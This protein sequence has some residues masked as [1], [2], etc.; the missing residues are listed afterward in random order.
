MLDQPS[1]RTAEMACTTSCTCDSEIVN[2]EL[3][4]VQQECGVPLWR[5]GMTT[6][7]DLTGAR[8]AGGRSGGRGTALSVA[9]I[10]FK[11]LVNLTDHF[12]ETGLIRSGDELHTDNLVVVALED[13]RITLFVTSDDNGSATQVALLLA[14]WVS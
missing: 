1:S 6:H 13:G 9:A 5:L 12:Y 7:V 3:W 10:G 14:M 8:M 2:A 4:P 11:G